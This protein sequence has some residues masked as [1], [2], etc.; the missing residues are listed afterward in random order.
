MDR[1]LT[2]TDEHRMFRESF[3]KFLD[4]EIVP[5]YAQ[6]EKD[7]LVPREV[8]KKFGDFG[9]LCSW[10]D[11]KYG[12]AN[13]DFLYVVI[14]CEELMERGLNGIFTRTHSH[15]IVPYINSAGTE[16]QKMKW[17]PGCVS[18]DLIA[19]VAMTE[20]NA[21]SDLAAMRT[22]AVK[23]GDF[24]VLN[25]SKTFIS[26]AINGDIF[27][28]AAKTDPAAKPA[29]KGITLFVVEKGTPGFEKGRAIEKIGLHAQDTAELFFEDCVVPA[30]NMLG[31]EGKGFYVLMK[32]LQQERIV[33]ALNALGKAKRCLKLTLQYVQEREMFGTTLSKFQ[34]TQFELAKMATEIEMASAFTDQLI[35]QHM[36]GKSIVK[37]V[38]MAKYYNCELGNRTADRCLQMFG[39]YGF[40][41]EY[42]IS[43]MYVDSRVERLYAGTSEV[44]LNIIA[45]ELGL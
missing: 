4:K 19:A 21:G 22:R 43:K 30:E 33:A 44:M 13:G 16:E 15:V 38:S 34:N 7:H 10:A 39:G 23:K 40:C 3:G 12:G 5:N 32:H 26:N 45:K 29:Y 20:P 17:I 9:F 25:G 8:W 1:I 28:V 36:Q 31:Q 18:G 41:E 6:W 42:P 35:M 14:E 37:E 27:V 11:E 2:F 24:Y